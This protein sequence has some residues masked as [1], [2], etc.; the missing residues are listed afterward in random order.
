MATLE[1]YVRT[2]GLTINESK[3]EAMK[4]RRGGRLADDDK[5]FLNEAQVKFVNS[6]TYLGVVFTST[7]SSFRQH[8]KERR[9]KT[10]VASSLIA[11]PY[12]LSLDAALKLF[13]LKLAPCAAYGVELVWE[14]L[15]ESDLALLDK[16]KPAFLKKVLGVHP[17]TRNRLIY[18]LT[19]TPFFVEELCASLKLRETPAYKDFISRKK[20]ELSEV[21]P[22]FLT[23]PAMLSDAWRQPD[24]ANRHVVIKS[25]THG[26]HHTVCRNELFHSPS[27]ECVC[28]FCNN[29]CDLYHARNC[30]FHQSF[31]NLEKNLAK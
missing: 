15:S 29:Y 28:K 11:D 17:N 8:I 16:S 25:S 12:R 23:S 13:A 4:F 5:I 31:S 7:G 20:R 9:R 18:L 22:E 19:G 6:F 21:D 3:T 26:Y 24:R 2:V 10:L 27:F 1:R 14:C 30:A